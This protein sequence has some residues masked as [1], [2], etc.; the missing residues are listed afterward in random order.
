VETD[1][2]TAR[3]MATA[4]RIAPQIARHVP[5]VSEVDPDTERSPRGIVDGIAPP[6]RKFSEKF[7]NS[8]S[9]LLAEINCAD[10]LHIDAEQRAQQ[11]FPRRPSRGQLFR[12][13]TRV[14]QR[15]SKM[16]TSTIDRNSLREEA[17]SLLA[18]LPKDADVHVEPIVCRRGMWYYVTRPDRTLARDDNLL[19]ALRDAVRDER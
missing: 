7:Q 1:L 9:A 18:Q 19:G 3:T 15:K 11:D 5:M 17:L 2:G 4:P 10:I 6:R 14:F 8:C 13:E 16:I 12:D